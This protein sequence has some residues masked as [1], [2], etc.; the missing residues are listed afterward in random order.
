MSFCLFL[1]LFTGLFGFIFLLFIPGN[2]C[3]T[4]HFYL[5]WWLF[6]LTNPLSLFILVYPISIHDYNG[7]YFKCM[8]ICFCCFSDA[9]SLLG[10]ACSRLFLMRWCFVPNL[11]VHFLMFTYTNGKV[12]WFTKPI[13]NPLGETIEHESHLRKFWNLYLLLLLIIYWIIK[14]P[15]FTIVEMFNILP[16]KYIIFCF[17]ILHLV[18]NCRK[19][20]AKNRN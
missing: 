3:S 20:N 9:H 1:F 14:N 5:Y 8:F 11:R 17:E 12:I 4:Y 15:W 16:L 19:C 10:T 2:L 13:A 7:F 6:W 18:L